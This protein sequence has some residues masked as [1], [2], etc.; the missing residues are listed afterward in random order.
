MYYYYY[1][2]YYYTLQNETKINF[3]SRHSAVSI[4][5]RLDD[6]GSV[7]R[8]AGFFLSHRVAYRSTPGPAKPPI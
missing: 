4:V 7:P 3:V 1:Y 8:R 5:S 2:Y 6:R